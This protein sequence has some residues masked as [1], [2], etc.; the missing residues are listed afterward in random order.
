M[1]KI[2]QKERSKTNMK[3]EVI[4]ILELYHQEQLLDYI[5]LMTAEEKK[6]LE[7]QILS[8]DFASLEKL[9][10]TTKQEVQIE[11]KLITHI[12]YTDKAKLSQEE[13]KKL[14][15]IGNKIIS[16]GKYAVVTMAGGQG[17]RLGHS[18]PKG[19]YALST[20]N[21][22]KYLFEILAET[23]K[24]AN[25]TYQVTIPWYIMTSKENNQQTV[26]FFEQHNY[27]GY[28][29]EYIKFFIQGEL[30][31]LTTEGKVMMNEKK[32]IKEAANGNGG[33]YESMEKDGILADMKAKGTEW[34]FIGGIDNVLSNMVDPILLGLT[35]QE[36][37]KIASKSVVKTNPKERVGVFCKINGKPK[38][39]EYT[40]LPEEMAEERDANGEL[41]FGEVNILS[42]L[43]HVSVLQNLA[44]MKLPFHVA[45]K[46]SGYLKTD[47]TY[48]EPEEPNA[49]K[50]EAFIFDAFKRY[51]NMTILR[52][53]REDEFAPVKNRTGNDSP[54]TATKLYNEKI[55]RERK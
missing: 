2:K 42:H 15:E 23:L 3:E 12:P 22:T 32:Q 40:E 30:P 35:I 24:K 4:Q 53:K 31:L 5:S 27:F 33:V 37:N 10:E 20:I 43:Y 38:V 50:F 46:K 47:G 14:Q 25:N 52:V 7:D 8:L 45:F 54:E 16:S 9:Y 55:E 51:D 48:I 19:S 49:Y 21:G 29:K 41:N 1:H 11:E 28:D 44:D 6:A 34:I 39:I 13:T 26:C 18:G 17:T 36:N